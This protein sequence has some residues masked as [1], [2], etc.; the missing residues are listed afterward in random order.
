[1]LWFASE[2]L[3]IAQ[4]RL[5]LTVGRFRSTAG[6]AVMRSLVPET[7]RLITKLK[8]ASTASRGEVCPRVCVALPVP[9]CVVMRSGSIFSRR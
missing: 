5:R 6:P 8:I 9:V 3:P 2:T 1:M 4:P 7:G